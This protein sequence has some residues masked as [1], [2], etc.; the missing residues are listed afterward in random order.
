MNWIVYYQIVV[1]TL[2]GT[3]HHLVKRFEDTKYGNYTWNSV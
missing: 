2:V 1:V 3:A